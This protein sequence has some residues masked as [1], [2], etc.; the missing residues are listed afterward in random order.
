MTGPLGE[1]LVGVNIGRTLEA[2]PP[3]DDGF[4]S[5]ER[6]LRRATGEA[7]YEEPDEPGETP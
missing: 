5:V 4:E 1:P 7:V 6:E 2:G 3:Q